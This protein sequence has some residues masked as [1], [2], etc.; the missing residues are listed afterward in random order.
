MCQLAIGI[1]VANDITASYVVVL[2]VVDVF[3]QEFYGTV[4]IILGIAIEGRTLQD[5][6]GHGIL[7]RCLELVD[8]E[9]SL[10]TTYILRIGR[11][12]ESD[13]RVV[14]DKAVVA[15]HLDVGVLLQQT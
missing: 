8:E 1:A 14:K 7:S 13:A 3:L 10:R 12:E 11:R 15:Y 6:E 2:C 9:L 5:F 4:I